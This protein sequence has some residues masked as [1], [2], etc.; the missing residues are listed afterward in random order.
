MRARRECQLPLTVDLGEHEHIDELREI[1]RVIDANPEILDLVHAD[2][3]RGLCAERGRKA[4]NA[5]QVLCA[6]VLYQMHRWT[7][8]EAAFELQFNQAYR[9]FCRLRFDQQPSKSAL[10]RDINRI[11]PDSWETIDQPHL[12]WFRCCGWH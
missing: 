2:L 6:A 7:F 3:L 12:D 8:R 5:E 11:D 1:S 10:Q 9:S 4:L